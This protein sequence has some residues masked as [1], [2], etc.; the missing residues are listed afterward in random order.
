MRLTASDLAF[1]TRFGRPCAGCGGRSLPLVPTR[2]LY[3]C[4]TCGSIQAGPAH[5]LMVGPG[6]AY[7]GH[8]TEVG[9]TAPSAAAQAPRS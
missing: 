2:D 7:L 4:F 6:G 9:S 5:C 3:E 1:V 8:K